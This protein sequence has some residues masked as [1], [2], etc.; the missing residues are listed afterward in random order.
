MNNYGVR[1]PGTEGIFSAV[2]RK[3]GENTFK[4]RRWSGGKELQEFW[5]Y[6]KIREYGKKHLTGSLNM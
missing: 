2:K 6:D 1:W 5:E 3:F 4:I